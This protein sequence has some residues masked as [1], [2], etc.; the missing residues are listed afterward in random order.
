MHR[1]IMDQFNRHKAVKRIQKVRREYNKFIQELEKQRAIMRKLFT[2]K[3]ITRVQVRIRIVLARIRVRHLLNNGRLIV[4]GARR[5]LKFREHAKIRKAKE[6]Y[7]TRIKRILF[8]MLLNYIP[9]SLEKLSTRL[10]QVMPYINMKILFRSFA[11]IKKY[12]LEVR[13]EHYAN[14]AAI[15]FEDKIIRQI[16]KA[17]KTIIGHSFQRKT[18]LVKSFIIATD[19]KT[20]NSLRQLNNFNMANVYRVR[21]LMILAW[22]CFNDDFIRTRKA[23]LLMP[24]AERHCDDKFFGRVVKATF[25]HTNGV[26]H[27]VVVPFYGGGLKYYW[28]SKRIKKAALIAAAKLYWRKMVLKGCVAFDIEQKR[29]SMLK[30][31]YAIGLP[32]FG[33]WWTRFALRDR[34]KTQVNFRK[35]TRR[36]ISVINEFIYKYKTAWSWPYLI[37]GIVS[38]K[39]MREL[40]AIAD[41]TK[42]KKYCGSAIS[43]WKYLME[44]SKDLDAYYYRWYMMQLCKR[45][46]FQGFKKNMDDTKRY[47]KEKE[48]ELRQKLGREDAVKKA[49]AGLVKAQANIRGYFTKKRFDSRKVQ[50]FY[51]IQ[52]LQ[53]NIRKGISFYTINFNS[54]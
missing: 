10:D 9:I 50:V 54:Y 28:R 12:D 39:M 29:C 40:N 36:V 16:M 2:E 44:I 41:A 27:L 4:R 20:H 1:A 45:I 21:R 19:I 3:M 38:S 51:A 11:F 30:R 8:D 18:K 25:G 31:F 26:G 33:V 52:V 48:E 53:N 43:S 24:K 42:F 49:I 46:L 22:Q 6:H 32:Q 15:I 13:T 14:S 47:R 7:K 34:F 17:W 35:H 5:W 23:E 37:K